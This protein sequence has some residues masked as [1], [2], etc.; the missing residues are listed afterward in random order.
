MISH[1]NVS[2][3]TFLFTSTVRTLAIEVGYQ[4]I[5]IATS[6][7]LTM[8][9]GSYLTD[10]LGVPLFYGFIECLIIF[11]YCY[12]AWKQGWTKA[13]A[14]ESFQTI[15]IT[16]YELTSDKD[17]SIDMGNMSNSNIIGSPYNVMRNTDDASV[18]SVIL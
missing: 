1:R 6:M 17:T 10:A 18:A 16:S 7:V 12:S 15:L 13:P 14:D 9:E 3:S 2:L 11:T 5:G 8:F 4:N